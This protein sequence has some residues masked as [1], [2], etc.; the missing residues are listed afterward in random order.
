MNDPFAPIA[1]NSKKASAAPSAVVV[2]P[3]PSDAPAPPARHPKLGSPTEKCT[4][5]DF[6]GSVIGYVLRFDTIDGK[7]F[8]PLTL[9]RFGDGAKSKWRWES[10]PSPRPLYHLH[11]LA[12]RQFAPVVV[13]E[14]EK[15]ADAAM[16]L[17]PDFVAVS[18]PNGSKSARKADWSEFKGRLVFVWPDADAAGLAYA[19]S[20]AQLAA[21]AGAASVAIMTPPPQVKVGWDA[22]DAVADGWTPD[23]AQNLINAGG[24]AVRDVAKP[25]NASAK[26]RQEPLPDA[27]AGKRRRPAQRDTLIGVADS[28]EL[29]HDASR[30]GYASFEVKGHRENW[31][32]RSRDFRMW[33]SGTFYKETGTAIGS[34]ALED[35]LRILEARAVHDG[36]LFDCFLRVGAAGGAIY[37]DLCDAHWRAVEITAQGWRIISE[38]PVKVLRSPSM[39]PL[40]EPEVGSLIEKELRSFLNVKTDEDFVLAVAYLVGALR[41]NGPY[42]ILVLNGEAGTGKSLFTRMLKAIVDPTAAPIRT[43]PRDDRD[44]VVSATHSWCLAFD[45]VSSIP[46]WAADALCRLATDSGF[47]TRTLTTD[48]DETTFEATRP[49]IL[50][51]IPH[52][53][54]RADLADRAMTIHLSAISDNDRRPE[55]GLWHEFNAARPRI[56]GALLDA[57]SRALANVANVKLDRAPRLADF[58]QWVTAAEPGLGWED[59]S[60]LKAYWANRRDEMETTFEADAVAVAIWE[61]VTKH[62]PEGFEGTAT[63]LLA[64][65][66]LIVPEGVKKARFWPADAA[67]L[68]DRVSRAMPVLKAKGCIV[69][70]RHSGNRTIT[71]IPPQ[72]RID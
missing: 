56:L 10:W 11:E 19:Q 63:Q 37:L 65:L 20:V 67:R 23:R 60:F 48:K 44:L 68:G 72:N 9:W 70:K 25:Q 69:V 15:A 24:A 30:T 2:M 27:D 47:A 50:N 35:G 42:P 40:P 45:N 41:P 13:C 28:V 32:I 51:G 38:P 6:T 58:A 7:E 66:N 29:W 14:G 22:A 71:I 36:P 49:V 12:V 26:R 4:Y 31:P 17:L 61:L 16:Q 43:L 1:A 53:T 3:V 21:A 52:L 33:L 34:Q 64:E 18:S 54:D 5:T 57:V 39:R 62:R 55:E 46:P 59:G 8:R